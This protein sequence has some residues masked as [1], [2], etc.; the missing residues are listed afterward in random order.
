[1]KKL[2]IIDRDGTILSEPPEDYQIDALHKFAF[3]SGVISGLKKI[4]ARHNYTLV[5]VT[6]QD[7]L[8][9]DSYPEKTFWPYQE[10]MLEVLKSEGITFEDI[11]IDRSRPEDNSEYRKPGT[12]MLTKYLEGG[13]DLENS[14]V[15]GDRW[16][17]VKLAENIG[18]KSIYIK[19]DLH[20]VDE[21][22]VNPTAIVSN[23]N[24][25]CDRLDKENRVGMVTRKTKE[26]NISISI[27]LDG[28]GA[29]EI[30]TGIGFYDHMLEQI[31][32]HAS[33]DMVVRAE[34]DLH[35]DEHHTIEDTAIT[36]GQVFKE[37]LG[38]KVGINRY[39]FALPMDDAQAQVL[40][41]FGGR[42][43]IEWDVKFHREKVGDVPTEMFFHFFKSFSDH[44][45]CNL[46]I[47]AKGDN[48]HH[49]IEGVFK[50]FA[51]SILMAKE[52]RINDFSIP[53]TKGSL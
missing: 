39:G 33:I 25:I 11:H 17:D 46:N 21:V 18:S 7:G 14:W 30:E 10:L 24:E 13:Y 6:N 41:D 15:I 37:A 9:T 52:K 38:K 47:S 49:V 51:K 42:P 40:I 12:K 35:I 3:L 48:D 29:S 27:N 8:G 1:M 23:W 2:L 16:S 4:V 44:C 36:L 53:S 34:G 5:M 28:S 43:W 31:S 22:E 20:K 19:S 32:K 45:E 50:A 26:T